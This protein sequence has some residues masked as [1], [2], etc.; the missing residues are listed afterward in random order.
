MLGKI[1]SFED[2]DWLVVQEGNKRVLLGFIRSLLFEITG[3]IFPILSLSHTDT[4]VIYVYIFF[5]YHAVILNTLLGNEQRHYTV[6]K[7]LHVC[8]ITLL[9]E[10]CDG[11]KS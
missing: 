4:R 9:I 5:I 6:L 3:V 1:Q 2:C 11:P 10:G 8:V 7:V